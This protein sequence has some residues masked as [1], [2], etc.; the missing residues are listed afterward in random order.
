MSGIIAG[1]EKVLV[2]LLAINFYKS[3]DNLLP[4]ELTLYNEPVSMLYALHVL[5]IQ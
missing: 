2:N 1:K 3:I 5:Y 4:N